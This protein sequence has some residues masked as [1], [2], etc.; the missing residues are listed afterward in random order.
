ML[1]GKKYPQNIRA[2]R[3][4]VEELL[5]PLFE[6]E[7]VN[8][9]DMDALERELEQRVSQNRTTRVWVDIVIR[10]VFLIMLYIRASHESDHLL[11]QQVCERMLLY[12]FTAHKYNYSWYGLFYVR[13]MPWILPC[14]NMSC[15]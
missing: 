10:P 4:L 14:L 3:P 9:P 1:S 5:R 8:I 7:T 12:V 13:S 2:L 6:D 15:C 11:H